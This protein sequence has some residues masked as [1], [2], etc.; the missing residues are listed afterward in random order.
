MHSIPPCQ[1]VGLEDVFNSGCLGRN[2]FIAPVDGGAV[3]VDLYNCK[4][5]A[6]F[7][8]PA[9]DSVEKSLDLNELLIKRPA[10]T[11][12]V[13][14][15][16]DS[17]LGAGIHPDDILVV[18][19]SLSPGAGKIVVCALNGELTVKRLARDDHQWRLVAANPDYPDIAIHEGL[20]AIIWGV[21]TASIHLI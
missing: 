18:D 5:V 11:F 3:P 8:S 9:D 6:G 21:V 14:V 15:E 4:V 10:A 12:F 13:R 2:V 1:I 17:M 19:R 20:E 16:G 7:P